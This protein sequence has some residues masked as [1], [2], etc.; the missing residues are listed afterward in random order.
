[1]TIAGNVQFFST[2][3]T[4][5][6]SAVVSFLSSNVTITGDVT[7][8]SNKQT[9]ITAY[10]STITLSGNVSFLNNTG[11][12][13]GAMALY[14][15]TLNIASNTSVYFY[16]NTATETGGAIYVMN[17]NMN[18]K[19]LFPKYTACFYQLLDYDESSSTWY[20]IR[21]HNNSAKNGG[22]HIYGE[23]MHS[24][25]CYAA[26]KGF[27]GI[28]P[29]VIPTCCTQYAFTY[30]PESISPVSSD[31]TRVCLCN[32]NGQPQCASLSVK[33]IKVHPGEKFTIHA[34][35]VGADLGTTTG[36]VH[37]IFV[38]PKGSV[39]LKPT[40]QYIHGISNN[41]ICS[42]L[43]YTIF[44][45]NVYEKMYLTV[46]DESLITVESNTKQDDYNYYNCICDD[47]ITQ[48]D[49][50][51]PPLL[52]ITLLPCPPGFTPLGDPPGCDCHPVLTDKE[53]H[54]Q[55]IN[56]TGY[57]SWS[58][59]MWFNVDINFTTHLAQYCP[60]D[61]CITGEKLV[62]FQDDADAQCL[63]NHAGTLCGG[64]KE[65]FSLAIGS[66]HCIYCPN[67]NNLALLIF[68]AAAG[69]L[70]VFFISALN[71]TVTQGMINGLLFYANIVWA[72]QS[73]LLPQIESNPALAF[74]RIFI[75][76]LNLD[77]GIQTCFVKGLDAFWKTWLQYLFPVYV[78][79]IARVIIAVAS[80][81]TKLTKL[82]GNRAVSVLATLFL[83][84]YTKIIQTLIDSVGFTTVD[85]FS[86]NNNYTLTVWSL[87]GHYTYCHFPHVLLFIVALLIFIFLS[88]PYPLLLFLMQWLR[89]KSHLKLLKWIPRF[90]PVYDAYLA[91][92]KD[93]HH[94]WFGALV[95]VRG[96]LLVIFAS[97][98]T[99]NPC[100]NHL[101]LLMTAALLLGYS[102]YH[103]VYKN[104]V[105]QLT[106][107]FFLLVLVI[108]GGSGILEERA[109]YAVVYA[110]IVVGFFAF[111]GLIV[112]NI[113]VRIHC[114]VRK[115]EREFIPFKAR[116]QQEI[117][118][119]TRFRDSI[120]D[121]PLLDK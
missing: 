20:D 66:S 75:A 107:N 101:V 106:E 47:T 39:V 30:F 102:N 36:A 34:V 121:E 108:V 96:I 7:F 2:R 113:F 103:R 78:W 114:K 29:I 57:H 45:Q 55:F 9:P 63:F 38:S 72:Y 40:S 120:L 58:G 50:Y 109:K 90:N 84:S 89:K 80:C 15:S 13:G 27:D 24:D 79:S 74:L 71:L 56:K 23:S 59:P 94:Y 110:S 115:V 3:N 98:Y 53:V 52:N 117:S 86:N 105:V 64:C 41:K 65:N 73:I 116:T 61:Y 93:K 31:P 76:W 11:I 67:N 54:C 82:L 16:N 42:E 21:F 88:L 87:D 68:F 100:I 97:T 33:S 19:F 6:G 18:L 48:A 12:N 60:F 28:E 62:N 17:E 44:S 14:S 51:T 4:P 83:L 112:W 5:N 37:A 119:S 8:A 81:S 35:V 85:V 46:K 111:C 10:S 95:M 92:L 118:N 25:T 91:P 104:K 49:L 22:D 69:F 26:V 43:N 70:L 1:M 32:N 77:F 99:V